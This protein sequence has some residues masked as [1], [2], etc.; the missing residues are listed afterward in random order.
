MS[1]VLEIRHATAP[2]SASATRRKAPISLIVLHDDPRPASEELAAFTAHGATVAP[3]YAIDACGAVTQLV[4]ESRAAQHS[5]SARWNRRRRNIDRISIG[6]VLERRPDAPY[7]DAQLVALH[8]LLDQIEKRYTLTDSAIVRWGPTDTPGEGKLTH[9]L[10]PLPL[11]E[12]PPVSAGPLVLGAEAIDYGLWVFLQGETYRQ[13]GGSFKYTLND[14]AHSQAFPV[15]STQSDLGAPVAPNDPTPVLVNNVS[16][17]YQ[18]FARALVFNEGRNFA[19]VQ[20][21]ND[22]LD[23]VVPDAGASRALLEASYRAS[24]AESKKHVTLQGR[25]EFREDWTFHIVA[26]RSRLGPALGGNYATADA[27]YAVQVFAGDTLYTPMTDQ[28]GCLFLS[29]TEP[30]DPAYQ[31]IWTETYKICGAPYDPNAPFQQRAA[32]DRLGTP[33]TG[34]Y[35]GQYN[36][37]A[38][39]I[40]VFAL[41]TLYAGPD[42]QIKRMSELDKPADI[43]AWKPAPSTPPAPPAPP[44]K[45]PVVVSTTPVRD[46]NWP[47]FPS[48]NPLPNRA[49]RDAAFGH[50]SYTPAAGRNIIIEPGWV[51]ANIQD[52][53]IPQLK[54]LWRGGRA[55]CHRRVAEQLKALWAAWESAGLL[56]LVLTYNGD[57]VPRVMAGNSSEVSMHA[58]GAAF[59][60]NVQWNQFNV[61]AALVG[62]NGSVRELAPIANQFGF[63]WGGHFRYSRHSDASDGMHFE[64]AHPL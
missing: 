37:T 40:Q 27:K 33:L 5:G 51:Q 1:E 28:A 64:W 24:L 23:D 52:V 44:P 55:Q 58:Y 53:S 42:G 11:L 22:L 13:R 20:N 35:Q 19:A 7:S 47:P 54:N 16:Y 36:G 34:V 17:N 39:Q 57:W 46:P 49:A 50:F 3:H 29:Q 31:P 61:R 26:M 8:R 9:T 63:Y 18:P 6:I 12:A 62:D 15:Y 43:K 38:Y 48:F 45:T 30:S 4:P 21:L 14:L 59:D 25:E 2:T 41:D 10:P 60:I 32:Q 56:H